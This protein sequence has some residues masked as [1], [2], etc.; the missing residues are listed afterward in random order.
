MTEHCEEQ[1]QAVYRDVQ[2]VVLR[3]LVSANS[4]AEA[5]PLLLESVAAALA[6]DAAVLWVARDG[7]LLPVARWPQAVEGQLGASGSSPAAAAE[8]VVGRVAST[9]AETFVSELTGLTCEHA[10]ATARAGF[11]I[12]CWLPLSSAQG[13]VGVLE[14]LRATNTRPSRTHVAAL[15][16]LAADLAR[17]VRRVHVLELQQESDI[18]LQRATSEALQEHNRQLSGMIAARADELSAARRAAR[19]TA[20]A[21]EDSQVQ[22]RRLTARLQ[23]IRDDERR[24]LAREIHD[25]L[26]QELTGLKMDAGW[27]LRRLGEQRLEKPGLA[28]V[29][30]LTALLGHIDGSI[31]KVRRIATELRPGVLDDLGLFAALEWHVREFGARAGLSVRFAA[32]G[33]SACVD[34]EHA[35]AVFRVAQELLTNVARHAL[36]DAVTVSTEISGRAVLLS[37]VDNGR[38]ITRAEVANSRS[39]GLA[40]VR[41]RVLALGGHFDIFGQPGIGTTARAEVPLKKLRESSNP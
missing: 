14:L 39:L 20:S 32:T 9:R 25:E 8:G 15:Q 38:G 24:Q 27:A 10:G 1:Q 7:S 26:G 41:E 23:Q 34:R 35:T 28:A 11:R 6:W 4:V 22:L 33:D 2:C 37:V 5:A 19:E 12:G 3:T 17:F 13:V 36:A 21:L 29:E 18:V 40:G 16:E 31:A 30:R